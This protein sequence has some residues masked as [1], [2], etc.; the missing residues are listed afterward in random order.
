MFV[1]GKNYSST[2]GQAQDTFE[3]KIEPSKKD[4]NDILETVTIEEIYGLTHAPQEILDIDI[5]DHK[6]DGLNW[7][8]VHS[9]VEN[10][11]IKIV[12]ANVSNANSEAVSID[13]IVNYTW[14][15]EI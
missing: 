9:Y 1:Y 14:Q 12:L 13:V 7:L 8:S 5:D 11:E 6:V 10:N 15:Q 2:W 3:I 4:E